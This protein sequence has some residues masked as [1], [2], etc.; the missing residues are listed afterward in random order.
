MIKDSHPDQFYQ[1]LVQ[2]RDQGYY[3]NDSF[4]PRMAQRLKNDTG[5]AN[6]I[7]HPEPPKLSDK[8]LEFLKLACT[9]MTYRE[10]ADALGVSIRTVDSYR[11]VLFDKLEVS[12]RVGLVL[13]S[14]KNGI[15][16]I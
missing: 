12:T 3:M 13:Y 4:S 11:D 16:M 15:V 2:I 14:I 7:S 6:N 5:Q 9:E 8:E 1:A 10:I